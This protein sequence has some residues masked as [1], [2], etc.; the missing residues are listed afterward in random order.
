METRKLLIADA[1]EPFRA[2]LEEL[3]QGP[4]RVY[5][6]KEGQETLSLLRRFAPD[7]LV[8]DLMLPG[9]DGI[10][11]LQKASQNGL[12]PV[13][14]GTTRFLSDYMAQML[15]HLG[16]EYVMIKPCDT[17]A[18]VQRVTELTG[19][20]KASLFTSPDPRMTVSNALIRFGIPTKLK[21]YGY[22]REAIQL[23]AKDPAQSITK[24]LYAQVSNRCGATVI[25]VERGIR[26]AIEAAWTSQ[27]R[28]EWRRCFPEGDPG[29]ARP[30]NGEFISRLAERLM[31]DSREDSFCPEGKQE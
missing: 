19:K 15:E 6:A 11:L 9:L 8:L 24:E 23:Y 22:L 5:T 20:L 7:V 31:L 28:E 4:F 26:T 27:N 21:G 3:L 14:L 1:S 10:S 13:V 2:E 25:Q 12:H 18:V 29:Y 30:S 16:V 17:A